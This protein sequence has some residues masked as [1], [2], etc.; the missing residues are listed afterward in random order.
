MMKL[1][2]SNASK[3]FYNIHIQYYYIFKHDILYLT[4]HEI[5]NINIIME[6]RED[7]CFT[8]YFEYKLWI[9]INFEDTLV[10]SAERTLRK[11]GTGIYHPLKYLPLR[12]L[13]APQSHL[14]AVPNYG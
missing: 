4:F 10:T 2:F 3:T 7:D 8:K 12:P 5:H 13:I 14:F 1:R 9:K 11:R 6:S